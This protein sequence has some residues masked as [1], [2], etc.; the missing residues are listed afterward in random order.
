MY[1]N[2]IDKLNLYIELIDVVIAQLLVLI[3]A[4]SVAVENLRY[5]SRAAN[6]DATV[7]NIMFS[8]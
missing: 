3:T 6:T 8:V 5:A 1:A 7:K 2:F 4:H